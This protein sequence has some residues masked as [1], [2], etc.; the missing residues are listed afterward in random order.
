MSEEKTKKKVVDE[1]ILYLIPSIIAICLALTALLFLFGNKAIDMNNKCY[2]MFV[3]PPTENGKAIDEK[4]V[5]AK[6]DKILEKQD[7]SGFTIM[8]NLQGGVAREDGSMEITTSYQVILMDISK[9]KMERISNAISRDFAQDIVL[10]EESVVQSYY[11][12]PKGEKIKSLFE[13][14]DSVTGE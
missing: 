2:H 10:V 1:R 13:Y 3:S 8:K 5:L 7:I 6:L 4:E 12:T 14:L 9:K 11:L